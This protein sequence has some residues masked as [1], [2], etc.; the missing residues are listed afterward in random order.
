MRQAGVLPQGGLECDFYA[1]TE[2][3]RRLN[4]TVGFGT[5]CGY[6]VVVGDDRTTIGKFCSIAANVIIGA[7]EHPLN[8]LSTSP[9]FYNEDLGFAKGAREIYLSP[10]HVGNDV[11]ICD[12]V[13]IK[14]GVTIGDGAVLAAGAV[15]TK[16]VPPYAVVAG[17]LAKVLKY[18]FAPDI[19]QKLLEL[20]WWN[21]PIEEIRQLP[22]KNIE[23]CFEIAEHIS[24]KEGE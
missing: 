19:V 15:V 9:F 18:R 7:G 5:Y 4:C 23:K 22:F 11:W 1:T 20:K 6:N 21:L 24:K 13:F 14:G 8:Y 10:V 12:N 16:D 3:A 2:A 17:V